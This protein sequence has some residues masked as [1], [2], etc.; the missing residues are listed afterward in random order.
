MANFRPLVLDGTQIEELQNSD[1]LN[2]NGHL[3]VS[4]VTTSTGGFVGDVT[5]DLTGDVTGNTSGTAGGLTGS[6]NITVG[7]ITA[8]EITAV[9]PV[10]LLTDPVTY[11][12]QFSN[13]NTPI[14]FQTTTTNVGCTVNTD[15]DKI[16]VP[17]AGTYLISAC[18]AGIRTNSTTPTDSVKFALRKNGSIFP[19]DQTF[20]GGVIGTDNN[21]E[22]N[23]TFTLPLVLSANDFLEIV[24]TDLNSSGGQAQINKGYFSVTRLH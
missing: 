21:E 23:F 18:I 19:N 13:N 10:C 12:A 17:T 9:Q 2:V 20:P 15:K 14:E 5:G 1:D 3:T 24:L 11:T 6:P 22:F 8:G 16:T 7:T 4:G